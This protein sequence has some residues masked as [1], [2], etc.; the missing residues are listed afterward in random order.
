MDDDLL[1]NGKKRRY[2]PH[3]IGGEQRK[4]QGKNS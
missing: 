1:E 4:S 2:E 3:L